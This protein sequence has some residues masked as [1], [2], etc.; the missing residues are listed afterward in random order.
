VNERRQIQVEGIVQGVGFRP[1]IY[2]LAIENGLGGFVLNDSTG[3]LIEL[4]GDRKAL[5]RFLRD[6]REQAPSQARIQKI[7]CDTI[8]SRGEAHFTIAPSREGEE[9]RACI[10]PDV[11]ICEECLRE[12][13]DAANRRHRYPFINCTNCGPGSSTFNRGQGHHLSIRRCKA[14]EG[15]PR[16][17]GGV[18]RGGGTWKESSSYTVQR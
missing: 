16:R 1:F 14:R 2:G 4:E 15:R 6:L 10:A 13:F 3:V 5:D 17:W 18:Q 11:A 7:V 9:R 8:P 12:L